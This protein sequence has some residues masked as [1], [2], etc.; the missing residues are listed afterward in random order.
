MK[1]YYLVCG[2]LCVLLTSC[3][4]GD[5]GC[6]MTGIVVSPGSAT[7]DHNATAP[8]NGKQFFALSVVPHGCAVTAVVLQPNWSV[9]D[10][11]DVS[12]SNVHD[13]SD[14]TATCVNATPG[15]VT[16]TA[17]LP[18]SATQSKTFVASAKL[19]CN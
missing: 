19:K 10:G 6:A 5:L 15:Q 17:T 13:G 11:V 18:K 4:G 8:G 9:S 14:G 2:L 1:A 3:G 7:A 16:V 12:I